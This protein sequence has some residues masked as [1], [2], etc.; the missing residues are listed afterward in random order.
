MSNDHNLDP[1]TDIVPLHR[2]IVP[3]KLAGQLEREAKCTH[4]DYQPAPPPYPQWRSYSSQSAIRSFCVDRP[5]KLIWLATW[6]GVLSWD[7]AAS[8]TVRHN[9][10][11]GLPGN[12]IAAVVVDALGRIWAAAENGGLAYLDPG[13]GS[14]WQP[15]PDC[16]GRVIRR[17]A[18][19][20]DGGVFAAC[21]KEVLRIDSPAGPVR[22][23]IDAPPAA[24][25]VAALA[26]YRRG[27]I[28]TGNA[29]GLHYVYPNG[30]VIEISEVKVDVSHLACADDGT[31]WIGSTAG[32]FRLDA[33]FENFSQHEAWPHTPVRS[34]CVDAAGSVWVSAQDTAGRVVEN[35]WE[36][37]FSAFEGN[38]EGRLE[39]LDGAL[40]SIGPDAAFR[41]EPDHLERVLTWSREDALGNAV[42]CL[43]VEED[44]LWVGGSG[45]LSMLHD[46][47][48][49]TVSSPDLRD[50]RAVLPQA[51]GRMWAARACWGLHLFDGF[52]DLPGKF[53]DEPIFALCA[54]PDHQ[55]WAA[56]P[57]AIFEGP[58]ASGA[59]TRI[60]PGLACRDGEII[61]ALCYVPGD[62]RGKL[63]IGTS[64]A[65]WAGDLDLGLW[66]Q[67]RG[68]W[69]GARIRAFV[70]LAT[71]GKLWA[72][73]DQGLHSVDTRKRIL[74]GDI[75][76]LLLEHPDRG[77]LWVG[78]TAGLH[79]LELDHLGRV[80]KKRTSAFYAHD[81][82]LA[83]SHV[84]ALALRNA[85]GRRELFV[86][87]LAGLSCLQLE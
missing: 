54:G 12:A 38:P 75:R 13:A 18:A 42:Q 49:R 30:N 69:D 82:G 79:R 57:H 1:G 45:T 68:P 72:A 9:T 46:D 33:S 87:S 24:A 3:R 31:V 39:T 74:L 56:A 16:A 47:Q 59:W 84:T 44:R 15:H 19:T 83:A 63:Y 11:H 52:I 5:R 2:D 76:A 36:P 14:S 71:L 55:L 78:T 51:R 26:P 4:V 17:L 77:P 41:V 6:G 8:H 10:T 22:R 48:W 35:E 40:F 37:A 61:Q 50:I 60:H 53:P 7:V 32:L 64:S 73:S 80:M 86:G 66:E 43:S 21:D 70:H 25:Y 81:S 34:I 65:I 67:V 20:E 27:L 28:L 85:Q 23:L 62:G 58:S 29:W